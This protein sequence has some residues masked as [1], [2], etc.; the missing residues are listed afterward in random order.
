MEVL[1]FHKPGYRQMILYITPGA[2]IRSLGLIRQHIEGA[3]EIERLH[4]SFTFCTLPLPLPI[5]ILTL[6][7][8]HKKFMMQAK[9]A[10]FK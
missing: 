2:L 7:F 8:P 4:H 10:Q 6:S 3:T 9:G 5:C 1:A